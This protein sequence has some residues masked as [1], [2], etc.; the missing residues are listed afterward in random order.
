MHRRLADGT[1]VGILSIMDDPAGSLVRSDVYRT[2]KGGDV[3][4]GFHRGSDLHGLP[5]SVLTDNAAVFTGAPRGGGRCAI[6]VAF[7]APGGALEAL[8]PEPSPD[9]REGG[10]ASPDRRRSGWGQG[11]ARTLGEP[12]DQLDVFRGYCNIPPTPPSARP[13]DP[14]RALRGSSE[15]RSC[16]HRVRGWQPLPGS[17][18]SRRQDQPGNAAPRPPA[19]SRR[20]GQGPQGQARHDPRGHL[21]V[22]VIREDGTCCGASP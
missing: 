12:Q 20:A 18:R 19:P 15:G 17:E 16:V 1:G 14:P 2:L 22:R 9:L 7:D 11:P 10:A 3:V 4:A 21:E 8:E 6:E 5:S 13:V